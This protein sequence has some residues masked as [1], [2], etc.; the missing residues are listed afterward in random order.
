MVDVIHH[1][2]I[3]LFVPNKLKKGNNV[4]FF[5]CHFLIRNSFCVSYPNELTEKRS[6]ISAVAI[7]L[8]MRDAQKYYIFPQDNITFNFLFADLKSLD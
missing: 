4:E 5:I 6:N 8:I 3:K 7:L 1:T 2:A